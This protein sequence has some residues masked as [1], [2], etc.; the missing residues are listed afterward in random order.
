MSIEERVRTMLKA[1]GDIPERDD[2]NIVNP[3]GVE[4]NIRKQVLKD[5]LQIC[6]ELR[7]E[8]ADT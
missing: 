4:S 5:V 2:A 6:E 1:E 7:C 3:W 8:Y